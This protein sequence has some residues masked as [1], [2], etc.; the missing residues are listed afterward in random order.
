MLTI[1]KPLSAGQAQTYHQREFT[2]KEQNYWSQ[3]G[4]IAGEWQ[5]RLA[6]Q[7]SLAGAVSAEDLQCSAKASTHR[8]ANSLC[9]SEHRMSIRTRKAKP[10]RRWNT[11]LVGTRHSP[12]QN[13]FLRF[14]ISNPEGAAISSFRTNSFAD[15]RPVTQRFAGTRILR[16]NSTYVR[17][18][19]LRADAAL[20]CRTV[21][22]ARFGAKPGSTLD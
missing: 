6:A 3:S 4:V 5:G 15:N 17:T 11:G 8:L 13:R 22:T 7:F 1:S 9:G 21:W 16:P 18:F 10:S 2:A 12:H 20:S 14:S 19:F